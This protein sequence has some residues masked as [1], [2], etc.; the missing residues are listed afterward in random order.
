MNRFKHFI[1]AVICLLTTTYTWAYDFSDTTTGPKLYYNITSDTIPYTVEV[2]SELGNRY[3]YMVFP[4]GDIV[5][6]ST[7][8]YNDTTY[9]VTQIDTA[10]FYYCSN[11]TSITIPNTVTHIRDEAFYNCSGL[12]SISLSNTLKEIGNSAFSHCSSLTSISLPNTLKEIGN[13]AFSFCSSLTSITLPDGVTRIKMNTFYIC[14][15]LKSFIVSDSVTVIE[16]AAFR[17]CRNLTSFTF[18][19]S[20]EI[21]ENDV[22]SRCDSLQILNLPASL[23]TINEM[24]FLYC[25]NLKEINVAFGNTH[26]TSINGI[27]Y[28][29]TGDTL[30]KCPEGKTDTVILYDSVKVMQEKSCMNSQFDY[31]IL[32]ASL[33]RIE[34]SVFANC[35]N[36]KSIAIPNSVNAVDQSAFYQ[37][38]ALETISIGK[39]IKSLGNYSFSR[40]LS[41]KSI[42]MK[43][44]TPPQITENTFL[45]TPKD[46]PVY[47]LCYT[48]NI[49]DTTSYWEDFTNIQDSTTF[50]V[51]LTMNNPSRG[52]VELDSSISCACLTTSISAT[53]NP[54]CYFICWSDGDTS[55]PRTITLN[56]DTVFTAIFGVDSFNINI[57]IPSEMGSASGSGVYEFGQMATLSVTP[58][59]GY[60]FVKWNDGITSNPRTVIVT[61]DSSFT[62]EMSSTNAITDINNSAYLQ[63]FPNPVND[64]L[65]I[66]NENEI[67]HK[68]RIYDVI[69]KEIKYLEIMDTKADI[70]MNDLQNGIYFI[71]FECGNNIII[72]RIFKL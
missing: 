35:Y 14:T 32:P 67:I 54:H 39:S 30:I 45:Q 69:G 13:G 57:N 43:S 16:K 3:G 10:A 50:D 21:L 38:Y 42:T 20:V 40:C 29:H 17:E 18:G 63:L 25:S 23:T 37:C 53:A 56:Q 1:L 41:L 72:R 12:T 5:I 61:Q 71:R 22:F 6:P 8:T 9:S 44:L 33:L 19:K 68:I 58:K 47:V 26:F 70:Y 48:K 24:T 36:L 52:M 59:S 11:I 66:D 7:I 28:N 31:I 15:G 65:H 55:N 34:K 27:L 62:A 4:T 64:V 49:Y 51:T 46:I 2:T 60:Q